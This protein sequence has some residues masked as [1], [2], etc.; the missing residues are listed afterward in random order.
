MLYEH[1]SDGYSNAETTA[2]ASFYSVTGVPTMCF[3][4]M[5]P[6]SVGAYTND[7]QQYQWYKG[8]FLARLA[9]P[10][11]FDIEAIYTVGGTGGEHAYIYVKVTN[12][13]G[14]VKNNITMMF[15]AY[16]DLGSQMYH[17]TCRRI[18][19]GGTYSFEIDETKYLYM[20]LDCTIAT[21]MDNVGIIV[22]AQDNTLPKKDVHQADWAERGEMT[23]WPADLRGVG[24]NWFAIPL[25]PLNPTPEAILGFDC[26][27]ILWMWDK[28]AKTT[29]VYRPPFVSFG[30]EVGPSYL[31][32]LDS[33][34][35]DVA[36]PGLAPASPFGFLMGKTGWTWVGKP[37][38]AQLGYPDFMDDVQV[39]YPIGG[40]VRTATEDRESGNPWLNWGWA[41]WDAVRQAPRTFTPYLPFGNNV[42]MPWVGYRAYANIGTAVGPD[43]PDQ[44]TLIWP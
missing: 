27:G 43:D 6:K 15:G 13:S 39:E 4:G 11:P 29:Q 36:Y 12:T 35:G 20:D 30:L 33:L 10:S 42:C 8:S 31:L 16:E 2:R 28:Y 3:D 1:V 26:T 21:N 23:T 32:R 5:N 22:F 9:I 44:V 24:W 40:E 34:P 19:S 18:T 37:G 14:Q 41:W 17:W 7:E 25:E 38:T